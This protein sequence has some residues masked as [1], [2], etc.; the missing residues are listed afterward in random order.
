MIFFQKQCI[1]IKVDSVRG[2]HGCKEYLRRPF[3]VC[4]GPLVVYWGSVWVGGIMLEN[5]E[6]GRVCV[7]V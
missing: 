4:W 6:G 7:C 3:G 5:V 1:C 2:G